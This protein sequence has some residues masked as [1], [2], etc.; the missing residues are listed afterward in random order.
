LACPPFSGS[1]FRLAGSDG[2]EGHETKGI[3]MLNQYGLHVFDI[4]I[5]RCSESEYYR[6]RETSVKKQLDAANADMGL[7]LEQIAEPHQRRLKDHFEERY[8]GPWQFNQVMG[9][10]CLFAGPSYVTGK[11]WWV[12]PNIKKVRS[13]S[14]KIYYLISLNDILST[15]FNEEDN[16]DDIFRKILASIE[17][18]SQEQRSKKRYVDVEVFQ[19][20]GRFLD[21]RKLLDRAA[22]YEGKK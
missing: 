22:T 6:R 20:I 1:F 17:E 9:W 18:F 3:V 4:P 10:L 16:S 15:C 2:E 11:L 14:H 19:N 21:W 8:G 12:A 5:Y 7:P 13:N